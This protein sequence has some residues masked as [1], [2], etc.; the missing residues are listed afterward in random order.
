M[1][2][3]NP[4]QVLHSVLLEDRQA[5]EVSSG[6]IPEKLGAEKDIR[7]PGILRS[8]SEWSELYAEHTAV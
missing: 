3:S 6:G 7:Y 2:Y 1:G 5:E 8:S 4:S